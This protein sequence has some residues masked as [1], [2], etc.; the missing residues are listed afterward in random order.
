M[1]AAAR[2]MKTI[3]LAVAIPLIVAELKLVLDDADPAN[4]VCVD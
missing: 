2:Q 4:T 3:A 1:I